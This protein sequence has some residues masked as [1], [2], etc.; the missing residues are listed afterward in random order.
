MEP[1]VTIGIASY[2]NAAFII[3]TLNSVKK[4]S[5]ANIELIIVDDCSTDESAGLIKDWINNNQVQCTFISNEKNKG[6][7]A[8]CNQLLNVSNGK[9][10]TWLGSDDI[11]MPDKTTDQVEVFEKNGSDV[12]VVF[13]EVSLINEKGV[14]LQQEIV[15]TKF[16]PENKP[17]VILHK[18][19]VSLLDG[20]YIPACGVMVRRNFIVQEGGYDESL[21][22]EDWYLWLKLS[23]KYNFVFLPK[24]HALY[25]KHSN[26]ISHGGIWQYYVSNIL[27]LKNHLPQANKELRKKIL[28]VIV[29]NS[30]YLYKKDPF[31]SI[32]YLWAAYKM[33]LK[34][35][36]LFL[37]ALA[38]VNLNYFKLKQ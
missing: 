25:R 4:Q 27:I 5:Y 35:K 24:T 20:N 17:F 30:I 14:V 32:K 6:L 36:L 26:S 22:I 23:Q 13:S 15:G 19:F 8:V 9:Y 21:I 34:T 18:P 12:A 28:H 11:L 38:F 29:D 2:N 31:R 33:S 16:N 3:E 1:L 37:L 10:I 7:T